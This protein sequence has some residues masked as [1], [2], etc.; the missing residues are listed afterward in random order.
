MKITEKEFNVLT[1]EET[2][3]ERE[4]TAA[5]KKYREKDYA[6]E[7]RKTPAKS[8]SVEELEDKLD[9]LIEEYKDVASGR[10]S[11]NLKSIDA[12]II[13]TRILLDQ[14]ESEYLS[15]PVAEEDEDEYEGRYQNI[16]VKEKKKPKHLRTPRELEIIQ[17]ELKVKEDE[18]KTT[19]DASKN[20]EY[21]FS[22]KK[23]QRIKDHRN[24]LRK[25]IT[26][27]KNIL[28][29]NNI[30]VRK[31]RQKKGG[32]IGETARLGRPASI[33]ESPLRSSSQIP[34]PPRGYN[35]AFSSELHSEPKRSGK[36]DGYGRISNRRNMSLFKNDSCVIPM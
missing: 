16:G 25:S 9:R 36:L 27:L 19:V 6:V 28:Y 12:N 21:N 11:G 34:T 5:E 23:L 7:P 2:I 22:E 32:A 4:E 10:T 3:T 29:A 15:R 35:D 20:K 30:M 14:R 1:G 33:P 17:E 8:L 31:P 24:Q 18:L 13:R 26:Q